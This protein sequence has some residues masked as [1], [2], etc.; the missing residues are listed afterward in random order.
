MLLIRPAPP[1]HSGMFSGSVAPRAAIPARPAP[2]IGNMAAL[3]IWLL[4]MMATVPPD[5]WP[6][7]I[8]WELA[9]MSP[10][11]HESYINQRLGLEPDTLVDPQQRI[12]LMQDS[13]PKPAL[14]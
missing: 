1:P 12:A 3:P 11:P 13:L 10:E 6:R 14:R 5:D 9:A 4:R 8:Y 2:P 7:W